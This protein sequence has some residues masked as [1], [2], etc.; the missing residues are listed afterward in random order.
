MK[1]QSAG[2][3]ISFSLSFG[4]LC[5]ACASGD[6]VNSGTGTGTGNTTGTGTG[7]STGTGTGNSTGH[8]GTTGNTT[9]TGTGNSTGHAGTTGTGTGNTTGTGTGNTTGTGTGNTTGTGTGNTTGTGT[10]NTTGTAGT[11][12]ST[13][14]GG[15][16]AAAC[17]SSF[18]VSSGGLVTMP[19]AG[20]GCWSGY[21]YDGGDASSAILPGMYSTCG[22]PC[23]LTMTGTVGS[24]TA[25]NSYV[26]NAYL[27]F[28]IGQVPPA[29]TPSLVTPKGSGITVAFTN[30]SS[31]TLRVQLNADSTGA[32]FW[33][34]SVTTSPVTIPYTAFTQ[35]CYNTTPGPAYAKQPI[36]SV[37]LSV[38]GGAA[39][40]AVNVTLVSVTENP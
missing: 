11:T 3:A 13:G 10:G 40:A 22:T 24:A 35:Q 9:G 18:A 26:G 12:G 2:L 39:A 37:S 30:A 17:G 6:T 20:G 38:P 25:A 4:L 15:T 32:T 5:F 7:N 27:G 16:T 14:T 34:T 29:T 33:C 1:L 19:A 31:S 36:Q 8:A 21:A 23:M 28:S